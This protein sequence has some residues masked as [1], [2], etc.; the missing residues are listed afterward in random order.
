MAEPGLLSQITEG[1]RQSALRSEGKF[2][3]S[4]TNA[5]TSSFRSNS[6]V[7]DG[8]STGK[9]YDIIVYTGDVRG[10]S[11]PSNV[12]ITLYAED[13]EMSGQ[14]SLNAENDV[15][16]DADHLRFQRGLKDTFKVITPTLGDLVQLRVGHDGT[17]MGAGWFLDK[18][19]VTCKATHR[20]Y[21]FL[22]GRWLAVD[23]DDKQIVR[24]LPVEHAFQVT[25]KD[26]SELAT[27]T[28]TIHAPSNEGQTVTVE[29]YTPK[30]FSHIRS[31]YGISSASFT[32]SWTIPEDKLTA[33]EG[34]G[35][36]GSL[37]LKSA[38][39]KFLMK[40]IPKDEVETFLEILPNYYRYLV[41]ERETLI[42]KVLALQKYRGLHTTYIIVF[43]N[44]L[45]NPKYSILSI[46]DLKGRAAKPGKALQNTAKIG[47][48]YVFKDKDLDRNFPLVDEDRLTFLNRLDKDIKFFQYNNLMD[49]SLLIGVSAEPPPNED[50]IHPPWIYT[51]PSHPSRSEVYHIGFI[52]CLTSYRLKKKMAHFFKSALW[53]PE[54]LS[55]IDAT[56]YA[57]RIKKYL[58]SIFDEPTLSMNNSGTLLGTPTMG[59]MQ[60]ISS[61]AHLQ[62][63]SADTL[64]LETRVA[65]LEQKVCK[66]EDRMKVATESILTLLEAAKTGDGALNVSEL[67]MI[68]LEL[69]H[70]FSTN[71]PR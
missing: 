18:V 56:S 43:A 54:T 26:F 32:E 2:G 6:S 1:I 31:L 21:T 48:D 37:F 61:A 5:S 49:Y 7:P 57:E 29:D 15:C 13:S 66:I 52:D 25:P 70:S 68:Q 22:C 71:A 60:R 38:D 23:E 8:E 44:V 3:N 62:S 50:V 55:T 47:T 9:G 24:D 36:S 59:S 35:R 17:G 69:K 19:E 41:D 30:V 51:R 11:T 40:T 53:T 33:K 58:I 39:G 45:Y 34:A 42:M 28:Y 63:M 67:N 14:I 64:L 20:T 46:Y 10:A 16:K 65:M 27:D 12:F 4:Y